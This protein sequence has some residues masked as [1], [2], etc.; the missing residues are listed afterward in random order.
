M[1]ILFSKEQKKNSWRISSG[2]RTANPSFKVVSKL[3][4]LTIYIILNLSNTLLSSLRLWLVDSIGDAG[5]DR[6]WYLTVVLDYGSSMWSYVVGVWSAGADGRVRGS[7]RYGLNRSK[8]DFITSTIWTLSGTS[9]VS[10]F[11]VS[12]LTHLTN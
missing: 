6:A 11:G 12:D 10:R 4:I 3:F 5:G 9:T 1:G 8:N 7:N 2:T